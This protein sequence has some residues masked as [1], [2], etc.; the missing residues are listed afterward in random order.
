MEYVEYLP[1]AIAAVAMATRLV[2]FFGV[3]QRGRKPRRTAA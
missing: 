1:G 2:M 3:E